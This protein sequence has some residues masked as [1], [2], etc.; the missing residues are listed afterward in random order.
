MNK[1]I[2]NS[3]V[4]V[5]YSPGHG[6]GWYTWA[7]EY[8]EIRYDPKVVEWVETDK[9]SSQVDA[10]KAYLEALYPNLYIGSNLI[11][12]EIEWIVLLRMLC[13]ILPASIAFFNAIV[14]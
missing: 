12:L 9:P 11:D 6:S 7:T 4:A 1:V 14:T 10:L 8:P 2:R 5:L 13:G 3:L